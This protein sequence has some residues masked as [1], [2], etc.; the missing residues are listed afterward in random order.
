MRKI[1]RQ[2][3]WSNESNLLYQILNQIIKLTSVVF[4]L[5]PKYKVFTALLTQSGGDDPNERVQGDSL[6]L[7]VSYYIS[8]N[9]E[10]ADLTI[11]GAPNNN[12]GTYFICTTAGVLPSIGTI[13]LLSNLGAPVAI[14]Q[15]NTLGNIWFSF[16]DVGVY[17][18][19][20]D[21]LFTTEPI[22]VIMPSMMHPEDNTIFVGN[23]VTWQNNAAITLETFNVEAGSIGRNKNNLQNNFFEIRIYN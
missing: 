17:Y 18:V 9:S 15:E 16:V 12:P 1:S 23:R 14:V 8:V 10:N 4:A 19:N 7:G 6:E 13:S 21:G 22:P 20:S 5:K 2:I 3:G 11:F